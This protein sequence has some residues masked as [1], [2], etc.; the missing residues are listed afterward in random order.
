MGGKPMTKKTK[1]PLAEKAAFQLQAELAPI[2][3]ACNVLSK[4]YH[5]L[6]VAAMKNEKKFA[7]GVGD[8]VNK[9]VGAYRNL[10]YVYTDLTQ[11]LEY[12]PAG[13]ERKWP[14]APDLGQLIDTTETDFRGLDRLADLDR[15]EAAKT[16]KPSLLKVRIPASSTTTKPTGGAAL[17]SS[18][19]VQYDKTKARG[20]RVSKTTK[21][22]RKK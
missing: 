12:A 17:S 13:A 1:Y 11:Y 20:H 3:A 21:K 15:E 16:A 14:R 9:R 7:R 18:S 8:A 10:A 4:K 5:A 22:G 19:V 2:L 6:A